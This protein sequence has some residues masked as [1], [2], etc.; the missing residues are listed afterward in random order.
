MIECLKMQQ[1]AILNSSNKTTPIM[2]L[3]NFNKLFEVDYDKSE[4]GIWVVLS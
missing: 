4:V 3:P 1:V 2:A